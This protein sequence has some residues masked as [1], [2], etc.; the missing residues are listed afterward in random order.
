MKLEEKQLSHKLVYECFFM[1]LFEDE[2][3]LPNNKRSKRIYIK[4]NS[5][6]AVLPITK[7]GKILL[8]KQYRYPIQ[9]ISVEIPAGKK[10]FLHE[11]GLS[12]ATRELE[13]ETR[14]VSS[15][16][17]F[18]INIHSC[19]GYSNEEIEIYIARDCVRAENPKSGDDDEFVELMELTMAEVKEMLRTSQITDAKTLIAL[20]Q[21][22]METSDI[23]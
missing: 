14:Y 21:Y 20:Q 19:V 17:D 8:V 3:L 4:H 15:R 7:E 23:L 22:F 2:V 16:F 6:A 1:K 12:C 10:D 18:L 11:D 9:S 13:E 5:A